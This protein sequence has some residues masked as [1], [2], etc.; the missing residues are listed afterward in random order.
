VSSLLWL[1]CPVPAASSAAA[2]SVTYGVSNLSAWV[3]L[4]VAC[5][6]PWSEGLVGWVPL[7]AP[8]LGSSCQ[9]LLLI[10]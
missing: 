1:G 4:V 7:F 5:S 2:C 9:L 3:V 6:I 8:L 10:S